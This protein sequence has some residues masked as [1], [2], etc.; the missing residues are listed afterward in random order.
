[1]SPRIFA[2]IQRRGLE[3]PFDRLPIVANSCNYAIRLISWNILY[4][5]HSVEL[6]LL[7]MYLLIGEI[8]RNDRQ[9]RKLPV[10]MGRGRHNQSRQGSDLP[11]PCLLGVP[12][13]I[14]YL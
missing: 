10:E 12:A 6:C 1:M 2:D 14:I 5:G 9:I 13:L 4:N 11:L 7:T 8:I 3:N